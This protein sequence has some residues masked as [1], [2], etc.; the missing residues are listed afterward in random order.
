[1]LFGFLPNNLLEAALSAYYPLGPRDAIVENEFLAMLLFPLR[2]VLWVILVCLFYP[3]M[4]SAALFSAVYARVRYGTAAD[5]LQDSLAASFKTGASYPCIFVFKQP[6]T[7]TQ[8]LTFEWKQ[9]A[10][11][12]G[13]DPTKVNITF[14]DEVPNGFPTGPC[15]DADHY[16][17]KGWNMFKRGVMIMG[18]WHAWIQVY[19]GAPGAPTVFRCYLPGHTFDGTSCFNMPKELISRY[20]GE[21]NEIVCPT[22]LTKEADAQL[23][24]LSFSTFLCKLPGNVLGNVADFNWMLLKSSRV[25]GGPGMSFEMAMLNYTAKDSQQ[26]LRGMKKQGVKPFAGFIYA[27]FHAYRHVEQGTATHCYHDS[28]VTIG[29]IDT[30]ILL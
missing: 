10:K 28:E 4:F 11:E 18:Q 26:M 12:I 13:M 5:I 23:R 8:K 3:V 22:H 9:L 20:Y 2:C 17:D 7:D 21:R 24:A 1:M 15:F 29:T 6:F 25:L 16:V 30:L 27:A 14:E 19:N